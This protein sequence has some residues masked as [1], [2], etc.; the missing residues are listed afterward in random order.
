[1]DER[2][3]FEAILQADEQDLVGYVR[4]LGERFLHQHPY[5]MP[6][7]L[8]YA[9]NLVTLRLYDEAKMALD[10]A[11]RVAPAMRLHLVLAQQGHLLEAQGRF[12]EA[13]EKFMEAHRLDPDDAT[14]LIY[15][16]GAAACQGD[17]YRALD[18]YSQ[19]S[20]CPEGCIDEAHFNR[21][22]KLL[23]L[24]RYEE[25]AEAYREALRLDPDDEIAKKRLEDVERILADGE[26]LDGG[27]TSPGSG[28]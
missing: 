28:A 1:M 22:G 21:G 23:A 24:K 14:Y 11:E 26:G 4:F 6:A 10:R 5:H 20:R 8:C 18:L 12:G 15:A 7:L 27:E 16:G 2:E 19:A 17:I 9:R 3:Q 13:E 25:A